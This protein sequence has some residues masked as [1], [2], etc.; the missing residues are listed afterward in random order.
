M[1]SPTIPLVSHEKLPEVK[2]DFTIQY[3]S[4]NRKKKELEKKKSVILEAD[5]RLIKQSSDY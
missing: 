5:P 2:V 1:L 3:N 4:M